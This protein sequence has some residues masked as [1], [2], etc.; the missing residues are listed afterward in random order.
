[1]ALPPLPMAPPEIPTVHHQGFFASIA[2]M[3]RGSSG[4]PHGGAPYSERRAVSIS[5]GRGFNL[6]VI[7]ESHHQMALRRV[8]N[9]R[10]ERGEDLVFRAWLLP[11]IG[12]P[13][14]SKA[15]VVLLD[16]GKAIGHL[17]REWASEYHVPLIELRNQGYA[18]W[19]RAT[20][21]GG[22]REK[23]SFGVLLDV[24][25]PHDGLLMPF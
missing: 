13:Y 2:A 22:Y 24:R 20:L 14:D 6:S 1:V 16:D 7:G 21:I 11:D 12:N 23:K 3:F 8:S 18:P 17:P 19:C 4:E 9:G 10:R 15:V 25:D 5:D